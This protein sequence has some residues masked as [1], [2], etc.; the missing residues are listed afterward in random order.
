MLQQY[1]TNFFVMLFTE[2]MIDNNQ[3][4]GYKYLTLQSVIDLS[5][6]RNYLR[7]L[8]ITT[9]AQKRQYLFHNGT[10]TLHLIHKIS[11][12]LKKLVGRLF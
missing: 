6:S 9:S 8:L 11:S 3:L 7:G 1:F 10:V 4:G 12:A 2:T 5:D